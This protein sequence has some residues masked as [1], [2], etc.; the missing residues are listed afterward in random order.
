MVKPPIHIQA[1][2]LQLVVIGAELHLE[3]KTV[4]WQE[5]TTWQEGSDSVAGNGDVLPALVSR[6]RRSAF[7]AG[8][9]VSRSQG[10]LLDR[11]LS[12]STAPSYVP[13]HPA[14]TPQ[15]LSLKLDVLKWSWSWLEN[16][17]ILKFGT[18]LKVTSVLI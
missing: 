17:C 15:T 1:K 2:L 16:S 7:P 5:T 13:F 12:C 6:A 4:L 18:K 8:F 3:V 10:S 11:N 9:C 14:R